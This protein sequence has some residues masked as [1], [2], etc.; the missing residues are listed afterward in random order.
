[1]G[2]QI[3]YVSVSTCAQENGVSAVCFDFS[4]NKITGDDTPRLSVNRYEIQHFCARIHL[5]LAIGNLPVQSRVCTQQ[6]LL[7]GLTTSV[8]CTRYLSTTKGTVRQQTS[9]FTCK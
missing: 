4:S 8:E 1:I 2:R 5:H 9:I 3:K 6:Q 7:S